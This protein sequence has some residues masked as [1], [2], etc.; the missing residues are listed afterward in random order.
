MHLYETYA[1]NCVKMGNS[2][3]GIQTLQ[4][5]VR[6]NPGHVSGWLR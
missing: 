3:E 1:D 4:S 2:Q 5:L 6:R